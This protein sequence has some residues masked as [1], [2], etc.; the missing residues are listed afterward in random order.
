MEPRGRPWLGGA[1]LSDGNLRPMQGGTVSHTRIALLDKPAVG[2][3]IGVPIRSIFGLPLVPDGTRIAS[4]PCYPLC[5]RSHLRYHAGKVQKRVGADTCR[6][7]NSAIDSW[8]FLSSW[9][10]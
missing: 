3:G 10:S 8:L 5:H 4:Y 6:K 9:G 7:E 1:V 2:R